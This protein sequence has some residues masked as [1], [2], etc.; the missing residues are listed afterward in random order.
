M[1]IAFSI[2]LALAAL[3]IIAIFFAASAFS[4]KT[5]SDRSFAKWMFILTVIEFFYIIINFNEIKCGV[6]SLFDPL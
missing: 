4:G 6:E 5:R 3:V 2:R 1:S